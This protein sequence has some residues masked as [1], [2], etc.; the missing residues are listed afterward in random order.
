MIYQEH[1]IYGDSF[2]ELSYM[3]N[4]TLGF[5]TSYRKYLKNL[6]G[7]VTKYTINSDILLD[8]TKLKLETIENG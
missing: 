6:H 3:G 5:K 4:F 2:L 7:R 8:G 1:P